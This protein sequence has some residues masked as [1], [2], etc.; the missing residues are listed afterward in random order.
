VA[1]R[2]KNK[3]T[4]ADSWLIEGAEPARAAEPEEIAS[5]DDFAAAAPAPKEE[6]AAGN[7]GSESRQWLADTK[8]KKSSGGAGPPK[9]QPAE[10]EDPGKSEREEI[11]ALGMRIRELQTELRVQAKAAKAEIAEAL[12]ERDALSER[13][14]ELQS[15]LAEA[16]KRVSTKKPGPQP[17]P[18]AK[19]EPKAQPKPEP[20]PQPKARARRATGRKNGKLDLNSA[21]FEELRGLGL[22]VTLSARLIAYRDVRGGFESLDELNEIP[23]LSKKTLGEIREQLEA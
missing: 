1:P 15:E 17:K 2:G 16:K 10:S 22:S 19:A 9:A 4:S 3:A 13:V 12:E 5:D 8:P 14:E 21:T 23:G 18:R 20:E 11:S 7:S 6:S